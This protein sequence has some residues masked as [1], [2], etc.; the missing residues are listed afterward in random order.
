[1]KIQK[2]GGKELWFMLLTTT[3]NFCIFL[4]TYICSH[5][6]CVLS[7]MTYNLEIQTSAPQFCHVSIPTATLIFTLFAWK[8]LLMCFFPSFLATKEPT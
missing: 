5:T 6:F 7:F 3:V 1:M 4:A 2:I 8:S